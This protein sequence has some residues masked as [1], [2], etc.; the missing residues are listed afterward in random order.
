MQQC[1]ILLTFFSVYLQGLWRIWTVTVVWTST[2]SP[3]PWNSSNW[4]SKVTLCPPRFLPVWNNPH[5]LYPHSP[6]LV[7]HREKHKMY[8]V[9]EI[10]VLD[11]W[12]LALF[13]GVKSYK[14]YKT[15]AL[16]AIS[17]WLNNNNDHFHFFD[18]GC[19]LFC[20]GSLLLSWYRRN[21]AHSLV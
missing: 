9:C 13:C 3:S 7:R 6:A 11:F 4:N 5:C 2:S 15:F 18:A 16:H 19:F 20:G 8:C 1:I 12:Q 10:I 17:S 14:S 21:T